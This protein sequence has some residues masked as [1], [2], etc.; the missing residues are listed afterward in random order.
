MTAAVQCPKGGVISAMS[1]SS[2]TS[3]CD[4]ATIHR[5]NQEGQVLSASSISGFV[6]N[7]LIV[8]SAPLP[9]GAHVEIRLSEG[10]RELPAELKRESTGGQQA[11]SSDPNVPAETALAPVVRPSLRELR[12]MPRDQRQVILAAAAKLAEEDYR[13]DKDLV[14]FE[15]FSEEELDD[16]EPDACER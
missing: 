15:A 3:R 16:A 12:A 6:K 11:D 9:E 1:H 5:V 4:W 8:P 10:L 2:T 13:C 7:G 14:G